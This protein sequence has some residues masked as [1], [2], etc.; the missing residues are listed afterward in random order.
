MKKSDGNKR[1][2]MLGIAALDDANQA[3]TKNAKNCTLIL[4]EGLSAKTFAVSGLAVVGRDT[5]GVFPLRGKLLNVRDATGKQLTENQEITHLKQILGLQHGKAYSSVDSL[6]YGRL[7]VMTDQDHDG[8][9]IKGLIINF[10][11][12]FFPGLLQIPG[13]LV[14][15]ITPIVKVTKGKKSQSFFTIPEY[16]NW[17]EETDEGRGWVIKYYK[18]STAH[19]S[20]V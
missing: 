3:G 10:L 15:F 5:Y 1:S 4:T 17:K 8:S 6:R 7:M 13:F 20:W 9:H 14:E 12:H 2:R 11:D 16:E 19:V 18:V